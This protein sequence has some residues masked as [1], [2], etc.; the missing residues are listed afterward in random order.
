MCETDFSEISR[1]K[2]EFSNFLRANE[3]Q[4]FWRN[5]FS[6]IDYLFAGNPTPDKISSIRCE[7]LL[8]GYQNAVNKTTEQ[9]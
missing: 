4:N 5:F 9:Y 3:I 2:G 7:I 6:Q 8:A 1:K